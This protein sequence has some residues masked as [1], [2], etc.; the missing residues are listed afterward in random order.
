MNL[1][2]Q[3]VRV[4]NGQVYADHPTL[5]SIH[6]TPYLAPHAVENL[7]AQERLREIA[8]RRELEERE[9]VVS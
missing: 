7:A 4:V 9:D 6:L 8:E 5:C 1:E 3:N 2:F